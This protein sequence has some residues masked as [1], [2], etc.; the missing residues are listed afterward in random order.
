MDGPMIKKV[1]HHSRHIWEID[2]I[3][4]IQSKNVTEE[5][6]GHRATA[7]KCALF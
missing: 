2:I 6:I 5:D 4:C 7:D 3:F 1:F